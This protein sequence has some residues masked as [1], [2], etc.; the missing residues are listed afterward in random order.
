MTAVSICVQGIQ[1]GDRRVGMGH[2]CV[3]ARVKKQGLKSLAL[4]APQ[5]VRGNWEISFE[6]SQV[7]APVACTTYSLNLYTYVFVAGFH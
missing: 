2:S 1:D 5:T 3:F 7:W 6:E 4:L